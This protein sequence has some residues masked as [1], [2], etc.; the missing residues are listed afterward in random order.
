MLRRARYTVLLL[1]VLLSACGGGGGGGG[2]TT[3]PQYTLTLTGIALSK[4]GSGEALTV[5][6]LPAQGATLTEE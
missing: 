5:T 1:V 2:D 6:G 3:G 4:K